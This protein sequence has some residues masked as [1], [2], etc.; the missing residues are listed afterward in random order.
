MIRTFLVPPC[1]LRSL[2]PLLLLLALPL[3]CAAEAAVSLAGPWRFELDRADAGLAEHWFERTLKATIQLPGALQ[4][5]GFGDE[6][7]AETRW[8]GDVGAD[9]WRTR[10]EYV[11]YRKP[12]NVK[13]PFF[14]Q[15]E[16]HYVG[17]AWYQR[18]FEIPAG[19]Q[20]QRVV[21]TFERAHWETRV[22][23]DG[24][25]FGSN[26]SLC[27]PHLYDFGTGLK[28]GKHTLTVRA[29]N[30]VLVAVGEWAHSVTDHTQGNWNGLIGHLGLTATSPVWIDDVQV[31]PHL[32]AKSA[33][34]RVRI[35]NATG[36]PGTGTPRVS[37][38]VKPV[39]WDSSSGTAEIDVSLGDRAEPWDE[40]TPAL[41]QVT[42]DLSGEQAS[43]QRVIRFG[44]REIGTQGRQFVLNGRLTFLRGTLECCIFP[45]TGFPP[46][47]LESW[48]RII[49]ICKAYGLNHIRFHSWCPPEAAF[50]AADELGFYYQV[51]CGVWA[52]PGE[53]KSVD[54]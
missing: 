8:T 9:R 16:K 54:Q 27:T 20:T 33:T 36:K 19:W 18:D 31:F 14:L 38:Q 50:A 45:L 25:T 35:G 2:A 28:P 51:E 3:A 47:D 12:G 34:V 52:E 13:V 39:T 23:L 22:W 15:P 21:L 46:T 7:T 6:V 48:K 49:R 43:D 29:D 40:F 1:Q 30:R 26:D 4:N 17:A 11:E 32:A 44:L 24:R 37:S 41:Q 42:V 53:G 10:P 5:E